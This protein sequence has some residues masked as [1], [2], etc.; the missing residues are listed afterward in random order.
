MT[1]EIQLSPAK[2]EVP[3]AGP[4]RVPPV[5]TAFLETYEKDG[6]RV[7]LFIE[8]F[9]RQQE[10]SEAVSSG[11]RLIVEKHPVWRQLWER[12][13]TSEPEGKGFSVLHSALMSSSQRFLIWRWVWM[14]GDN[15]ASALKAK[16]LEIRDLLVGKT[17][18]GAGIVLLTPYEE[19]SEKAEPVL[20]EFVRDMRPSIDRALADLSERVNAYIDSQQESR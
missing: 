3:K 12:S 19:R 14:S 20:E 18:A 4:K 5:P 15:T 13:R 8:F 16:M 6:K 2:W 10:G 9:P 7:D 1:D 17:A 11:N